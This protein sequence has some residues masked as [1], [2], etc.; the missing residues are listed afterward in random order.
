MLFR[1]LGPLLLAIHVNHLARGDAALLARKKVSVVHCPR[2]HAYFGHAPIPFPALTKAGVNV[3]LGTDSLATVRKQPKHELELSLFHEMRAFAA[4]H[5]DV[6]PKTILEMVTCNAARALGLR[7]QVGELKRGAFADLIA[8]PSSGEP[9]GAT[10]AVVRHSGRV[11]ASMI[12]G[13]WAIAPV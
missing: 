12:A 3:C 10:A 5:P 7:G 8:V 2:S 1:S 4:V 6:A 9:R 13:R 11:A